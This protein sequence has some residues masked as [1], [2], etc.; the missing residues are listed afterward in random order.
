MENSRDAEAVA[1]AVRAWLRQLET[2]DGRLRKPAKQELH[3]LGGLLDRCT[4]V[5]TKLALAGRA[6]LAKDLRF[7]A[8]RVG[9]CAKALDY[10]WAFYS[11]QGRGK[12]SHHVQPPRVPGE[13]LRRS[14]G[15]LC[16]VLDAMGEREGGAPTGDSPAPAEKGRIL[17]AEAT[18]LVRPYLREHPGATIRKVQEAT[19]VS[20]GQ[21]SS[22]PCWKA[23]LAHRQE[24][25]GR[26]E[27]RKGEK[28]QEKNKALG[29][30][31]RA[32]LEQWISKRTADG[33]P[34]P[35]K[36]EVTDFLEVLRAGRQDGN[37]E[38]QGR[39]RWEDLTHKDAVIASGR[40]DC[41][42]SGPSFPNK[43]PDEE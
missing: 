20:I 17:K 33:L 18:R 1:K 30:R 4:M 43:I 15:K 35:S 5:E 21:I 31:D 14:V 27:H 25:E 36:S 41:P 23:H 8:S 37:A 32:D 9:A 13:A 28:A 16:A 29:H 22:L 10:S 11:N 2:D 39:A 6:R 26:T 42:K 12:T 40:S 38:K 24:G 3:D 7:L 19:G 34:P